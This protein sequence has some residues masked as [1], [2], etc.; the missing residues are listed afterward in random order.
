VFHYNKNDKENTIKY[1]EKIEGI[2]PGN[3]LA[4]QI[5]D[6]LKSGGNKAK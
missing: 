1:V 6:G 3:A 2:E 5:R 4:K